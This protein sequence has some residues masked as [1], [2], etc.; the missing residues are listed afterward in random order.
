MEVGCQ[1]KMRCLK[2]PKSWYNSL[3]IKIKISIFSTTIICFVI[4][5]SL[6]IILKNASDNDTPLELTTVSYLSTENITIHDNNSESV[7]TLKLQEITFK[8]YI[9]QTINQ[10]EEE[11]DEYSD[12]AE[13]GNSPG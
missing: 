6:P 11:E 8:P 3:D 12:D 4:L 7:N 9:H 13:S 1:L 5:A 2:N 10:P